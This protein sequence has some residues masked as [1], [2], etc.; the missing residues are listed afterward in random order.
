MGYQYP[1]KWHAPCHA[2]HAYCMQAVAAGGKYGKAGPA[3]TAGK[4]KVQCSCR[5]DGSC[6]SPTS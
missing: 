5:V 1:N 4:F 2:L 6:T 3:T